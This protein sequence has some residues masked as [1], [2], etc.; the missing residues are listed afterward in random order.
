MRASRPS[1][2]ERNAYIG[3][4]GLFHLW[5]EAMAQYQ[6]LV[7]QHKLIYPL[8][9]EDFIN[10]HTFCDLPD[11]FSR[12]QQQV[13]L[14][15]MRLF[16]TERKDLIEKYI[17]RGRDMS[18]FFKCMEDFMIEYRDSCPVSDFQC[19]LDDKT[20]SVIA[21]AANDIPLF[22]RP[23]TPNDICRLF[24]ECKHSSDG[25]LIARHNAV[26]AY[27]FCL[28]SND[29]IISDKYQKVISDKRLIMSSRCG[30]MLDQ[31]AM[32]SGLS[33]FCSGLSPLRAKIDKW[34]EVIKAMYYRPHK[35]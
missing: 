13:N 17:S 6:L 10:S 3:D 29:G 34:N 9:V 18:T 16:L 7:L 27:F 8:F 4:E 25:T 2:E 1:A 11:A 22:T 23:V 20:V 21:E 12:N 24:N 19:F 30:K 15:R 5:L 33:H 28:L 31:G 14:G 26:L 32:S 35:G